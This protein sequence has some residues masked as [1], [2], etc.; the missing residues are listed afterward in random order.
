MWAT[1]IGLSKRLWATA[2]VVQGAVG[3][4]LERYKQVPSLRHVV[5][6]EQHAVDIEVWTR[7]PTGWSRRVHTDPADR[8]ALE[9]PA[10]EVPV[11]ELY[12][13]IERLPP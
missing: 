7:G 13:G 9:S 6:V 12:A 3:D 8:F 2:S 5:L 4:K 10:L 1:R 11:G